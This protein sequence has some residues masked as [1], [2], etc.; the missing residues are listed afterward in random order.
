[1]RERATDTKRVVTN[2]T[3]GGH[4]RVRS[5]GEGKEKNWT[6]KNRNLATAG[7]RSVAKKTTERR[8]GLR[9]GGNR[10]GR[11]AV[12]VAMACEKGKGSTRNGPAGIGGGSVK[13]GI[14]SGASEG[15]N[16]SGTK[17]DDWFWK[18]GQK[19]QS[20]VHQRL[21]ALGRRRGV[22]QNGLGPQ[23]GGRKGKLKFRRSTPPRDRREKG[24]KGGMEA[25]VLDQKSGSCSTSRLC[26]EGWERPQ[27]FM[28]QL[29]KKKR[30]E[31]RCRR[32]PC[33][34]EST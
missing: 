21:R 26:G 24:V 25:G 13:R 10:P 28:D 19:A 11:M 6:K 2:T 8:E 34:F 29:K 17:S 18:K 15:N 14:R 9:R 16:Q 4:D 30:Q 23:R 12:S 33:F 20:C 32:N 5:G 1:M 31:S 7:A 22:H 27:L 3:R